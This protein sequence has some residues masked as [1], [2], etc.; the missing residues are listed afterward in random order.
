MPASSQFLIGEVRSR[1]PH[2][3]NALGRP[4]TLFG[5]YSENLRPD[6]LSVFIAEKDFDADH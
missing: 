5:V 1:V 3:A 6:Y 2:V 4:F